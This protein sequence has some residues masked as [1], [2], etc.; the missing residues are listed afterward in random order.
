MFRV[1]TSEGVLV[2]KGKDGLNEEEA[3]ADAAQ[4]NEQALKLEI[5]TRY[6]VLAV[7]E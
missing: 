3:K 1:V 2:N 5:K 4:R 6:E 7:N